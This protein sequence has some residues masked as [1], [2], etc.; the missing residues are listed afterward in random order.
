MS[1]AGDVRPDIDEGLI[2]RLLDAQ[3]PHLAG[4]PV[5]HLRDGWDNAIWRL[6]DSLAIR[7]TRRAVAVD[8]HRHEQ[9]WLPI[10]APR[11]PLPVPVPVVVGKPSALFPWPWSVVPWFDGDIAAVASP[12]PGQTRVLGGFLAALHAAPPEDVAPNPARGGDLALHRADATTWAGQGPA[13]DE[14]LVGQAME[15]VE[16]GLAA[17]TATERVWIHGDLHARNVLVRQGELCAVL[18]WGDVTAG[19][20][21]TD[22]AA[23]WWLFDPDDHAEFWSAYGP[24]SPATWCRARAWAALFG[25]SFLRFV[26]PDDQSAPD[27]AAH[28]LGR[29]VLHRVV[30]TQR[31]Q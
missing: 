3:A 10:L 14:R 22:L 17:A 6:G 7:V 31:Q 20:A 24:T 4:L 15:I 26:L 30:S 23:V 5:A 25:L 8:L 11:L 19:D 18:D 21:A 1:A 29:R 28:E 16:T 13:G 2:R 9:R 27:L 12:D